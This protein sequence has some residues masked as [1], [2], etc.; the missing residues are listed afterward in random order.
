MNIHLQPTDPDIPPR[1]GFVNHWRIPLTRDQLAW[2]LAAL[3][4]A[5]AMLAI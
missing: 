5:A 2:L 4:L 1:H 3:V